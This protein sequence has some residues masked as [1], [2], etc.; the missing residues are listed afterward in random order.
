MEAPA[1]REVSKAV[2]NG[3]DHNTTNGAWRREARRRHP[4]S[5]ASDLYRQASI[6]RHQEIV[7][8][9]PRGFAS[10]PTHDGKGVVHAF[11]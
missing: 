2:E 3:S 5:G 1:W 9:E 8:R 10:D 11:G 4:W 6:E 7:C